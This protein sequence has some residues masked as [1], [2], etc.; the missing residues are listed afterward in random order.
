MPLLWPS[1]HVL[2]RFLAHLLGRRKCQGVAAA[3]RY[4]DAFARLSVAR[5]ESKS[6]MSSARRGIQQPHFR[7]PWLGWPRSP[8][9][10]NCSDMFAYLRVWGNT[11][12]KRVAIG[13]GLPRTGA[14]AENWQRYKAIYKDLAAGYKGMQGFTRL[15]KHIQ[16][17]LQPSHKYP[18]RRS[19]QPTHDPTAQKLRCAPSTAAVENRLAQALHPRL[20]SSIW[21]VLRFLA[22]SR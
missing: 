9:Y 2:W 6:G 1:P 4:R 19:S 14:G 8:I 5:A 18:Q 16:G 17:Y 7:C 3:T 20:N 21:I 15:Y 11:Q 22:C 12:K 13:K 10:M